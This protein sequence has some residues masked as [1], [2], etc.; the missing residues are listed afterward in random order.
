MCHPAILSLSRLIVHML[1]SYM[2]KRKVDIEKQMTS[3]CETQ[4]ACSG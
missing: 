1:V 2:Q 4:T 3:E